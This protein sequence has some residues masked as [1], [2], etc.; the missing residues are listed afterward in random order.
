[1]LSGCILT[2]RKLLNS[3]DAS[4]PEKQHFQNQVKN[5]VLRIWGGEMLSSEW[6]GKYVV[7]V[8]VVFSFIEGER[9]RGKDLDHKGLKSDTD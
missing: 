5:K 3:E 8:V 2:L 9:G 7:V 4:W 1:M 6:Q